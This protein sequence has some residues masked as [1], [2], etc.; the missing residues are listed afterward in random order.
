MPSISCARSRRRGID[1]LQTRI[2]YFTFVK[3]LCFFVPQDVF[4]YL[5]CL[6]LI[7]SL[8]S[9]SM[10][11]FIPLPVSVYRWDFVGCACYR[12]RWCWTDGVFRRFISGRFL[13]RTLRKTRRGPVGSASGGSARGITAATFLRRAGKTPA[14]GGG[15]G[16]FLRSV[17][18][19]GKGQ[20][21]REGGRERGKELF[22][23]CFFVLDRFVAFFS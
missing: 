15:V 21:G 4:F 23:C 3:R 1:L 6:F 18:A 12:W 16:A 17:E 2:N 11:I 22:F 19:G 14:S 9:V 10:S 5:C 13:D 8:P 7:V 20:G